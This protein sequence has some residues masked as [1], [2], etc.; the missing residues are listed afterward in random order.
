MHLSIEGGDTAQKLV[1]GRA[2]TN[3]ERPPLYNLGQTVH[4]AKL[5]A[6]L[7]GV[8]AD[9]TSKLHLRIRSKRII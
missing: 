9:G 1:G 3:V 8:L 7:W 4:T 6:I 2:T 5:S